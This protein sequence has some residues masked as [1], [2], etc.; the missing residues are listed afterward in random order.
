MQAG[1]LVVILAAGRSDN[2]FPD[3]AFA[4]DNQRHLDAGFAQGPN[5]AQHIGHSGHRRAVHLEYQIAD[6]NAGGFRRAAVPQAGDDNLARGF[7]AEQMT[8]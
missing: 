4:E 3:A 2:D 8:E 5:L 6:F 7:G 1:R